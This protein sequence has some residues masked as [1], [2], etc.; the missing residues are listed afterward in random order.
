MFDIIYSHSPIWIQQLY[1]SLY[2]L[3]WFHRRYGGR[4]Q[5]YTANLV[6]RESWTPEQFC[7]YQEE[8]LGELL[9]QAKNS[10]YYA[11]VFRVA[12]VRPEMPPFEAL[13]RLPLLTKETLRTRSKELLTRAPAP[14]G[15]IVFKSSGTTGTPT[16]IYYTR[17]LHHM[18]VAWLEAR[19]K[20]WAGLTYRDR[21]IMF[22]V[23]KVCN[24]DQSK[25]PFWR[26]SPAENMAYMSIYHLSPDFMS[27]YLDFLQ[28]YRPKVVMG[29]PSALSTLAAFSLK[30]GHLPP[31]AQAAITTSET[32]TPAI[33]ETIEKA[34]QCKLYDTYGAVEACFFASECEYGRLH[35][36]P[37]IGIYEIIDSEGNP[38]PPGVVG[39]AICTG[40]HNSLQPLI[41]YRIG[42][43]AAW[44]VETQCPC[45]RHMP[46]LQGV[47]GRIE[48]MCY[49]V[50]GRAMLRFD[51]VFKGVEKILEAQVIQ[52][53]LHR[54]TISVVPAYT[55]SSKDVEKLKANM[56]SHVG[57]V[58]VEVTLVPVLPRTAAGKF[59]A[60]IS[61]LTPEELQTVKQ[62]NL[63][64]A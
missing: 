31:P 47:E 6:E 61:K 60:V 21:R 9:R 48:D 5:D 39:E 17:E 16:E 35:L 26:H 24:F 50:D 56:R 53:S 36:S 49:T 44:S 57:E 23:R 27:A 29:Y 51:T 2:G 7:H 3:W 20:R 52:E 28:E 25:P 15:T 18:E 19:A 62:R 46:V 38:C 55:F 41:R 40:L 43:A 58:E 11:E 22:G 10:P 63:G 32:V 4:F 54:F 45:G 8:R 30:S 42:D 64:V 37:D 12:G 59:R 33:R 1:V 13:R 14:G 34:W